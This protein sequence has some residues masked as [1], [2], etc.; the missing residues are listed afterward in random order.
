[1]NSDVSCP[2]C[3]SRDIQ[4]VIKR[5]ASS[6]GRSG[7]FSVVLSFLRLKKAKADSYRYYECGSCG[8]EFGRRSQFEQE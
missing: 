3:N 4:E 2:N 7:W 5:A 8:Y 6:T 1:M